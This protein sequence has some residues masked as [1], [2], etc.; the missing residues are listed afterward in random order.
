MTPFDRLWYFI[1]ERHSIYLKREAGQEKPWTDDPILQKYRFTNVYRENDTV[2]RWIA[3]NWRTPHTR[4][5]DL[6]FAM[7]VAR[8]V[9]WPDTLEE[10]GYPIPWNPRKFMLR[11]KTR[12]D[13]GDKV[14]TGAY[15]VHSRGKQSKADYLALRVLSPLWEARKKV[16]PKKGDTLAAFYSRLRKFNG[17]GSFMA[18]QVVADIKYAG[19]LLSAEDWYS[20]AAPGPGSRRGLNRLLGKPLDYRMKD[21]AWL[22]YINGLRQAV[23]RKIHGVRLEEFLPYLHSQAPLGDIEVFPEI[24]AQ[25]VQ[26]CLCEFDKMERVR[27]GQGRPRAKYKGV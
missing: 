27:L 24:H 17:M 26:N 16:R 3:D 2:T 4:E 25:D 5:P 12:T 23:L 1:R 15:I 18:A 21:I 20:F 22:A 7:T 11:M 13:R 10:I 19:V 6:W 8:Y 9:N 14:F